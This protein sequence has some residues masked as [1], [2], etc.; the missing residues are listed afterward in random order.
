MKDTNWSEKTTEIAETIC[1]AIHDDIVEGE[2]FNVDSYDSD[3]SVADD[4]QTASFTLDK[5]K[6]IPGARRGRFGGL[7]SIGR[8]I[9]TVTVTAQF[10]PFNAD[11]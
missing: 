11:E 10:I 6:D 7:P 9:Y 1:Q 3:I 5:W 8:T 4:K 2:K